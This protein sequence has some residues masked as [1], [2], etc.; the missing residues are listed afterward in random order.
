MVVQFSTSGGTFL[1]GVNGADPM[2]IY[3]G[4]FWYPVR[5]SDTYTIAYDGGTGAFTVGQVVTGLTSGST[6]TITAK[7]G[8]VAVGTL[9][10]SGVTGT[11]QD[12]ETLDDPVT[13]VALA[14]GTRKL[15]TN[16]HTLPY[17]TGTVIFHVGQVI[18][19]GTSGATAVVRNI[20]GT[21]AAGTLVIDSL[22]GT[23][24]NNEAI[25]DP[26]GGAAL[27][28]GTST[29]R[30]SGITGITGI[31]TSAS[32]LRLE[33][34][35][36]AVFR[37]EGD[38]QRL[39]S[40]GRQHRR[41]GHRLSARRCLQPGRQP[42]LRFLLEYREQRRPRQPLHLRHRQ[43]DQLDR[44]RGRDRGL[45][46]PRSRPTPTSGAW[47]AST[48]PACRWERRPTSAP[49]ATSSSPPT[50]AWSRCRSPSSATSRN[51]R[52]R[53][54]RTRSRTPGA[55]RSICAR[56]AE[57]K[58]KTWPTGRMTVVMLPTVG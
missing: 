13:G 14:N 47:S 45:R 11:F 17:D 49:G 38:P 46:R 9:T 4:S 37:R 3:D 34:Q 51:W 6:G 32:V 22:I 42:A 40:G 28:N 8:T 53:P 57:W 27:V 2:I 30:L 54:C 24:Q 21:V 35:E 7:T 15:H 55:T 50:S 18:T 23:F 26:L 12:N 10:L 33:L 56:R 1:V 48:V 41:R 44:Q 16:L 25:T 29:L 36:P 58:C 5:G 43:R 52:P 39:V 20:E 31:D 19:G